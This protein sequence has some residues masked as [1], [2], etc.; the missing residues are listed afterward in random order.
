[1]PTPTVTDAEEEEEHASCE[2]DLSLVNIVPSW[3][4]ISPSP[5]ELMIKDTEKGISLL[6]RTTTTAGGINIAEFKRD[7]A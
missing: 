2:Y 1:M 6:D 5:V 7:V 4:S 3:L